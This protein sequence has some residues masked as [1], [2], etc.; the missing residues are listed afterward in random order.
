MASFPEFKPT[1]RFM[2][3]Y[4]QSLCSQFK[5]D[6]A[7]FNRLSEREK[8]TRI[9]LVKEDFTTNFWRTLITYA[10]DAKEAKV[11][12]LNIGKEGK[13]HPYLKARFEGYMFHGLSNSEEVMSRL[14][15]EFESHVKASSYPPAHWGK[16]KARDGEISINITERNK[17]ARYQEPEKPKSR[18]AKSILEDLGRACEL[19]LTSQPREQYRII[20]Q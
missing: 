5:E 3:F 16:L 18:L 10:R 8:R 7:K 11:E 1:T 2:I 12:E 15:R 13:F 20:L 9:S 19:T 17:D 6:S 4:S 14:Y